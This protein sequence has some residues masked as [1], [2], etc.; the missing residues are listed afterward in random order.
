MHPAMGAGAH[1]HEVEDPDKEKTEPGNS[2]PNKI[3]YRPM[4]VPFSSRQLPPRTD[5][6]CCRTFSRGLQD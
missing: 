5:H 6:G 4:E 2:C 3:P 1:S